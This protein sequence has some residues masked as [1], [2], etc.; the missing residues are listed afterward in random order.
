[1][2]V[3]LH[4][5]GLILL[6]AFLGLANSSCKKKA[7]FKLRSLKYLHISHTKSDSLQIIDPRIA[8]IDFSQYDLLML[9]GDLG[10]SSSATEVSLN[11][12]D[13]IYDLS[14]PNTLWSLGNHDYTDLPLLTDYTQRPAYYAYH[15]NGIT[16]VVLDTQDSS[17]HITG[18]QLTFFNSVLDTVENSSHLVL[19]HH[20][21]IWMDNNITLSPYINTVS[22][23]PLG[24]C[25]YC[26]NPNN[27]YHVVYPKLVALR[28]AGTQVLCIGGDL[29]FNSTTFTHQT[30]EGI[31]FLGSGITG[32]NEDSE[33]IVFYHDV[34][35]Q[36]LTW[37]FKRIKKLKKIKE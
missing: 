7:K 30:P 26:L 20:K 6:F 36:M 21:L 12:L 32:D 18:D 4:A 15:K 29:G 17:C 2:R 24:D 25:H 35:N 27:F 9:G 22:N 31:Q 1:M 19:L 16:F 14:N 23:G 11:R 3:Q 34:K 10:Y 8:T 28:T 13:A 5:F 33:A 37:E